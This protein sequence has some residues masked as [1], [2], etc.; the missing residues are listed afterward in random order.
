VTE[1][2]MRDVLEHPDVVAI[3]ARL[4]ALE[5]EEERLTRELGRAIRR[6]QAIVAA[7]P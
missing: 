6:A 4:D 7:R 3:H 5:V 1:E 2:Q